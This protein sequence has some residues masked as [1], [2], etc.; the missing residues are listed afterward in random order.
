MLFD[1][2]QFFA[3]FKF[4]WGQKRSF[5]C[6]DR[7]VLASTLL[8]FV[9]SHH[10]PCNH[11]RHVLMMIQHPYQ[12]FLI[13]LNSVNSKCRNTSDFSGRSIKMTLL[14]TW[15]QV[16][17]ESHDVGPSGYAQPDPSPSDFKIFLWIPLSDWPIDSAPFK[18]AYSRADWPLTGWKRFSSPPQCRFIKSLKE[19]P[20]SSVLYSGG[21]FRS[22]FPCQWEKTL[23]PKWPGP[24]GPYQTWRSIV[25]HNM[26][27]PVIIV[28]DTWIELLHGF[29]LDW[30]NRFVWAIYTICPCILTWYKK[31]QD[32]YREMKPYLKWNQIFR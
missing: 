32:R 27:I 11:R 12:I 2:S 16:S 21:L 3:V 7:W 31:V 6:V 5:I 13:F 10:R 15:K 30:L 24:W 18:P 1:L 17:W 9:D 23:G 14:N 22:Y 20:L 19:S 26:S 28:T 8:A 4:I 29:E 25:D